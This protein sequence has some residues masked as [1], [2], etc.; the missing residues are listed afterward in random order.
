[1][2]D[3]ALAHYD[4]AKQALSDA[5]RVDE[6]KEIRNR[7][8]A[9]EAYAR[10][11]RDKGLEAD[12]FEIRKRAERRLGEM[13]KAQRDTVGLNTGARGIGTKV[14]VI[15]KP[16]LNSA[17]IDKNLA[18]RARKAAA[19]PKAKFDELVDNGRSRI[20]REAE[21]TDTEISQEAKKARRQQRESELALAQQQLP[22]KRYGVILADPEWRFE[23]YSRE[24]GM[25][26]SA[27]NHYPTSPLEVIK[28]RDVP[29]IAANDC[30]LFLWATV[31]MLPQALE[32]MK[33]W[34]FDYR[35]HCIWNKDRIGTGHWFRGKHEL[36]LLGARG[37]IPAPAPGSQWDS[38]IEAKRAEHSE[39]PIIFHEM[40][41]AYFPN[42]PKI[43]LNARK[44]RAGWD[45]WG[46][47]L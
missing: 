15:G 28:A 7:A 10:Q 18:D 41:E 14:R 12:A 22:E 40:I 38:V 23:P 36:L 34:G 26:R 3:T 24:T 25:D 19:I 5:K 37:Q 27:D 44:A 16:T 4:T 6:V 46:N 2:N 43:E 21:R 11:A 8:V 17:G 35:S 29:S 32:V 39:K 20:Q 13:I 33:A 1:M 30:V 31:P 9:M 45:A 47:E 42:L